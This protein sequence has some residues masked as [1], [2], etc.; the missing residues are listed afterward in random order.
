MS[1]RLKAFL[2]LA[3][4]IALSI[5]AEDSPKLTPEQQTSF[6]AARAQFYFATSNFNAISAEFER[7][8]T[9]QQKSLRAAMGER[10]EILVA[11]QKSMQ[12]V[13]PGEIVDDEKGMKLAEC[14]P[15][16]PAK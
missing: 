13:C 14:K 16:Q 12:S 7:S 15:K 2:S 6:D 3:A 5:K 10:R 4:C 9:D 1:N 11:A 8:L